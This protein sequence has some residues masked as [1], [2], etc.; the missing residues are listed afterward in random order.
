[1]WSVPV[2][3]PPSRHGFKYRL[4]YGFADRRLIGYDNKRGKGDHR[5]IEGREEPYQFQGWEK[6]IDDFL[7]DVSR[8]RGKP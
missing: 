2:P 6:L 1:M 4:F 7:A 5:H 3:V 8:M